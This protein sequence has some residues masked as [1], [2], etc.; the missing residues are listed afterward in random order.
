MEKLKI[1]EVIKTLRRNKNITQEQLANFIGIS[2]PAV[3]KWESSTSY[4]DITVLPILANYFEVTIDELLNYKV[5]LSEEE[6]LKIIKECETLLS[7]NQIEKAIELCEK[8][9]RNYPSNYKLKL[10]FISVYTL[11]YI[12]STDNDEKEKVMNKSIE[13]LEDVVNNTKDI[14]TKEIALG[15]LSSQYLIINELDKAEETI[16]KIYKPSLNPNVMLPIIYMQQGKVEDAKKLMQENLSNALGEAFSSCMTLAMAYSNCKDDATKEET[17]FDKAFKYCDLSLEIISKVY[18]GNINH[19]IYFN[20]AHL[21]IKKGDLN[22]SLEYLDK[23]MMHIRERNINEFKPINKI[24]C[25]DKLDD[26][27]KSIQIDSYKNII[28]A[29]KEDFKA[30]EGNKNF[31]DII[32]ELEILKEKNKL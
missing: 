4:P 14:E 18:E 30:L 26:S 21:C 12:S 23:M 29:L 3:S 2:K 19:S 11:A 28:E 24:W 6:T 8:I 20:F 27:E 1:G 31:E 5:E 13:I 22:K 7:N 15:Q 9:M 32:K 25:F 16:K 10:K 17:D